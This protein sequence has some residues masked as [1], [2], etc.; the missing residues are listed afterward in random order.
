MYTCFFPSVK[1]FPNLCK[2]TFTKKMVHNNLQNQTFIFH[3]QWMDW[4]DTLCEVPMW[5]LGLSENTLIIHM[6][7][8]KVFMLPLCM[9]KWNYIHEGKCN[10]SDHLN[11]FHLH[12]YAQSFTCYFQLQFMLQTRF[13]ASI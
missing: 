9:C 6:A 8:W 2:C 5:G 10:E 7:M 13:P 3:V 11:D 1:C 4:I 12:G